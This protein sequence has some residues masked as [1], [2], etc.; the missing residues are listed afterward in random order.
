MKST[1]FTEEPVTSALG[2]LSEKVLQRHLRSF[3]RNDLETLMMD[4]TDQ[5]VLITHDAT[6]AG[7][8]EIRA[9]FV[10]LM[11]HFP[12]GHSTF[13][14][15]KRVIR[16]ELIFIVWHGTTP[17]LEVSMGTDTFIIKDG[18]IHQQ[19]FAGQMKFLN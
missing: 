1:F 3:D 11:N 9:F 12:K 4:Y 7:I 13:E 16:D 17:S 6:Y 15:V 8:N 18:K 2:V 10:G 19:T 14:L 5:S